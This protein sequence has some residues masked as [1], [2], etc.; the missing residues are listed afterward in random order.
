MFYMCATTESKLPGIPGVITFLGM[1]ITSVCLCT[2]G[3]ML[4]AHF[5]QRSLA[6]KGY[7]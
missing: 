1:T 2:H 4:L 3:A 6:R 7:P 5:L